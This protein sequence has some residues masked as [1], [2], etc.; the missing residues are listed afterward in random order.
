MK[1]PIQLTLLL[2][3]LILVAGC[4]SRKPVSAGSE[5]LPDGIYLILGKHI[6]QPREDQVEGRLIKFSHHFLDEND[7]D[8]PHFLDVHPSE[9][10]PLA[11]SETPDSVTQPDDRI[12]LMLTLAETSQKQLA[13]F[14]GKH[15]DRHVAIVIGQEAMTMHKIRMKITGGKLQ[16]TRCTD[17]ACEYLFYELQDNVILKKDG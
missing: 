13:R 9:F 8:Q 14:T 4:Q 15:V 3:V 10:V 5:T 7:K 17:N 1:S 2:F 16:I 6:A 12:H 11:L